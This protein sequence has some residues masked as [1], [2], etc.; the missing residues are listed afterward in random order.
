[1]AFETQCTAVITLYEMGLFLGI[2]TM[3]ASTANLAVKKTDAVIV[4]K[5]IPVPVSGRVSLG[6]A[7][8]FH[9][10]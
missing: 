8:I 2:Q 1:M 9:T 10:D 7:G 5:R 4:R 3:T 6:N